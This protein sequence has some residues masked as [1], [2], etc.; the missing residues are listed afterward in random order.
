[1]DYDLI[2]VNY[3]LPF[4]SKTWTQDNPWLAEL[5]SHHPYAYKFLINAET[6]ARKG[7]VDGDQV[8]AET[9]AGASVQGIV[10][11]SQCIHP[12]VIGIAGAFGHWAQA[13]PTA[14][15]RGIHFNS[16]VPYGI[17]QIDPMAGLMDAC[18]KVKVSKTE[19]QTGFY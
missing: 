9:A 12:E 13:R 5:A 3:K 17:E 6:A 10:T 4:H 19:P 14:R 1:M 7:I 15:H 8:L 11:V 16:L 2:A 18:V